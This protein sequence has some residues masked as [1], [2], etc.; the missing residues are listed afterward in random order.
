MHLFNNLLIYLTEKAIRV[1][2]NQLTFGSVST[3]TALAVHFPC[4]LSE[5]NLSNTGLHNQQN[6]G[7]LVLLAHDD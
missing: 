4:R 2:S 3:M 7:C 1:Y 5:K 6:N